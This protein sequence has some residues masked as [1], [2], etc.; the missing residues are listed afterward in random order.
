MGEACGAVHTSSAVAGTTQGRVGGVGGWREAEK[1]EALAEEFAK[2]L[3]MASAYLY[4]RVTA[5]PWKAWSAL[6]KHGVT[7]WA[8]SGYMGVGLQD[9]RMDV[10]LQVGCM[11]LQ[12]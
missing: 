9:M 12:A 6:G 11:V 1:R 10:G 7:G 5:S 4:T 3:T 8:Q 2:F